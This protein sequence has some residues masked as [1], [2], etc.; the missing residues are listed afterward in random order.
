MDEN[1]IVKAER[2]DFMNFAY[3]LRQYAISAEPDQLR[4]YP[5]GSL[6]AHVLGFVGTLENAN[7]ISEMFGCDGIEKFFN[8]KLERRV[9]LARDGN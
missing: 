1:K 2:T 6:A 4:V 8:D 9:R 3:N 5:N 7:G